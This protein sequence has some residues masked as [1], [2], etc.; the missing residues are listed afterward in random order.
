MWTQRYCNTVYWFWSCF[1][2]DKFYM[3]CSWA[4]WYCGYL[5]YKLYIRGAKLL[6]S[7]TS[8]MRLKCIITAHCTLY[9]SIVVKPVVGCWSVY[10]GE[11]DAGFHFNRSTIRY[12]HHCGLCVLIST[13]SRYKL[14]QLRTSAVCSYTVSSFALNICGDICKYLPFASQH[15]L[16][17]VPL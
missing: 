9:L 13:I 5:M 16:T 11:S 4:E 17:H 6:T 14:W 3:N 7:T 8:N 15:C 12:F 2:Q 10:N 1:T